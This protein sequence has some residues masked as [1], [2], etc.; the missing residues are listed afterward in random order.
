M[1]EDRLRE[2]TEQSFVENKKGDWG[3]RFLLQFEEK[4]LERHDLA[5]F[6]GK[7]PFQVPN[8]FEE[9]MMSI[10]YYNFEEYLL[11]ATAMVH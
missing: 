9:T 5:E 10:N 2:W 6:S 11:G 8:Y 7:K 4:I 1:V 3:V